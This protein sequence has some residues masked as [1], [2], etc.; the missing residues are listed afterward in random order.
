L[1]GKGEPDLDPFKTWEPKKRPASP[2][3]LTSESAQAVALSALAYI[4]GA[5]E[6][7]ERF[8][9]VSGCGAD[10]LKSRIED[11]AFLGGVLDFILAHEPTLLAFSQAT[12]L[13]AET[14]LAARAL[15][16]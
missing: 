3:R 15:L 6:L 12:G 11:Q 16:P 1:T 2:A 5:D 13:S 7:L 8:V 9:A 10:E 4:A 14:P